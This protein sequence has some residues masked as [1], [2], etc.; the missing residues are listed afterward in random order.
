MPIYKYESK[1]SFRI[2]TKTEN[3][4]CVS[5]LLNYNLRLVEMRGYDVLEKARK[6][7]HGQQ[8]ALHTSAT[9]T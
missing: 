9:T 8:K 2:Y 7:C 5:D 4:A 6:D 3:Q 1:K